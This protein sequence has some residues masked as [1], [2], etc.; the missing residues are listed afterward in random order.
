DI[1]IK[2]LVEVINDPKVIPMIR[3]KAFEFSVMQKLKEIIPQ[4]EW[5]IEKPMIN[6]QSGF[7]DIDI[8]MIHKKTDGVIRIEC[9]LAKKESYKL[10]NDSSNQS[11]ILVKCMRSRTLGERETTSRAPQLGIDKSIL[12]IHNDQYLPQDFD[13]VITSIGNAFYITNEESGLYM[14]KPTK[15]GSEFLNNLR[16]LDWEQEYKTL[17]DFTFNR[18]YVVKSADLAVN[19]QNKVICTRRKCKKKESCGFIP[20]YPAIIFDNTS[21]PINNW[22]RIEDSL[23]IFQSFIEKSK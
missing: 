11:V 7:H 6:A 15:K 22:I 5:I 21:K 19:K 10:L 20:N 12:Q 1:P 14:W 3:G 9:K 2:Y 18:M 4:D 17:K 23:P 13:I 16:S 8:R